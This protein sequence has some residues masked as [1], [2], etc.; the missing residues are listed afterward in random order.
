MAGAVTVKFKGTGALEKHL[1][2]IK[3]RLGEPAMVRV[4]FLESATYPASAE[5]QAEGLNVATVAFWN[6]FGTSRG[7]DKDGNAVP[8]IPSRPFFRT[9]VASK[10]PRWGVALGNQLRKTEYDPNMSLSLMGEVIKGQL[11]KSI[12]TWSS[13]PNAPSTVARKGFNKP[14]IHT[15]TMLRSVDYQVLTG[16]GDD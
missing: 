16:E 4:G 5:G 13:P 10:S 11:Q 1:K 15:G 12:T 9:M 8:G 3:K 14:L 2:E 6:E 7:T